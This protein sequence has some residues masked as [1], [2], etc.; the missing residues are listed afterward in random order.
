MTKHEQANLETKK[1]DETP[2]GFRSTGNLT[3]LDRDFSIKEFYFFDDKEFVNK[4]GV[5]DNLKIVTEDNYT[6]LPTDYIVGVV[7]TTAART[8]YLPKTSI[9]GPNKHYI[10]FDAGG[11]ATSNLITING[12]GANINGEPTKGIATNYKMMELVTEG[13]NWYNLN[14]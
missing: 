9:V 6:L 5:K 7:S 1:Q 4:K 14:V 10:I 13:E 2:E 8:I 3:R 11:S 12:N